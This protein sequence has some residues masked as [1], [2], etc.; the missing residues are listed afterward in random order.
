[1]LLHISK[2][3][4]AGRCF[5]RNGLLIH[6]TRNLL[7]CERL[8]GMATAPPEP[9]ERGETP[10]YFDILGVDRAF[11]Q[12]SDELKSKYKRLMIEFHP[13]RHALSAEE[14]KV[15]NASMATNV[16]R[17]YGVIG[18]P[19]SRALHLLELRGAA[20]EESDSSIIDNNLLTEIM[21]VR[22]EI[23]D[24]SS[25]NELRALLLTCHERQSKLYEKLV[26]AFREERIE[27]AKSDTAK[28]QYWNRVEETIKEK[29]SSIR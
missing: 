10:D 16:T 5:H 1:M 24:A 12:S 13:D 11:T 28:L 6:R 20:I 27:D 21:E 2:S 14:E 15:H 7:L 25:D 26:S 3:V 23:E 8:F 18:D 17:A 29:I 19:L 22:E 9:D 4:V